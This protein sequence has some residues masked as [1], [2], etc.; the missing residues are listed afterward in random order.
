MTPAEFGVGKYPGADRVRENSHELIFYHLKNLSIMT[1]KKFN[2]DQITAIVLAAIQLWNKSDKEGRADLNESKAYLLPDT[3]GGFTEQDFA[4]YFAAK[5][6]PEYGAILSVDATA[7]NGNSRCTVQFENGDVVTDVW[8]AKAA[9][10]KWVSRFA[11]PIVGGFH[12]VP[13]VKGQGT[14][15]KVSPDFAYEG[16]PFRYGRTALNDEAAFKITTS[17]EAAKTKA[18]FFKMKAEAAKL[19]AVNQAAA[20]AVVSQDLASSIKT[21]D[22][23]IEIYRAQLQGE[24]ASI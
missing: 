13:A 24:M 8:V 22:Q 6:A 16:K 15:Q 10:G 1:F 2:K 18:A 14:D 11:V 23:W 5:N 9:A 4:Q 12:L 19:N 17:Y 3:P 7:D 21:T 20:I